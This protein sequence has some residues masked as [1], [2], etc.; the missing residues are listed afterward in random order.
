MA[1]ALLLLRS[2]PGDPHG[3]REA[4]TARL[5]DILGNET[6]LT[7][8]LMEAPEVDYFYDPGSGLARPELVLEI[9]TAPGRPLGT[10]HDK[11][12]DLLAGL[13]IAA[14]S[15]VFVVQERQFLSCPPEYALDRAPRAGLGPNIVDEMQ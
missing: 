4:L 1:K 9:I 11:M 15:E 6:Q 14:G 2:T 13:P 5:E 7:A 8:Q 12:V 3:L 10:V